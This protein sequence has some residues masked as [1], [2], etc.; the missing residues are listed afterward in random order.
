MYVIRITRPTMAEAEDAI[1]TLW[2]TLEEHRVPSP[3]LSVS[4]LPEGVELSV[5]F[6]SRQ[7]ADLLR[8]ITPRLDGSAMAVVQPAAE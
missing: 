4:R 8:R 3:R 6:A 5:R 2:R 1:A 7:H